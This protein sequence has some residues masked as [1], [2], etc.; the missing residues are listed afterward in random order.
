M[1]TTEAVPEPRFNITI[2]W[3]EQG[4][5]AGAGDVVEKAASAV[6][7]KPCGGCKRRR[8]ALNRVFGFK[9]KRRRK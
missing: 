3:W 9:G 8:K 1:G 2:P 6:G 7:V 4:R 5:T